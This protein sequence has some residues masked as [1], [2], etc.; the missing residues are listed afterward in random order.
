MEDARRD[1]LTKLPSLVGSGAG[2][3]TAP[4]AAGNAWFARGFDR[5]SCRSAPPASAARRFVASAPAASGLLMVAAIQMPKPDFAAPAHPPG[6]AG[7][8]L[9]RRKPIHK[10]E[11]Y[12]KKS[13]IAL[14]LAT[15]ALGAVAHAGGDGG[16][17]DRG[18]YLLAVGGCN[19]CHTP[20]F[21][22]RGE[23]IPE[24]ERLTGMAVGFS[25]PWGVSYP[26]NLR[27]VAAGLSE[28]EWLARSRR[29]GL[30]PMPWGALKAM[31]DKDQRAVYRY[32][33][34][35]GASGEAAPAALP[36]G[37]PIPTPHFVF[38][39]QPPTAMTL[40]QLAH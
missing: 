9:S 7:E 32:L 39:P 13:L 23:Q 10:T 24:T 8:H 22:Q 20:G 4:A 11:R 34:H 30:P 40:G 1:M 5:C 35:L 6:R 18:R 26:A 16:L 38:V 2:D 17:V 21:A 36:P 37:A 31:S 27:L 29:G 28:S 12:M 33:R 15:F 3:V 25:G 14:L 19:D